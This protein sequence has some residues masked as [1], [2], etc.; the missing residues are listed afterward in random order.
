MEWLRNKVR[1]WLR[2]NSA[3]TFIG[4][5]AHFKGATC[6]VV[7]SKL[8]NGYMKI[9]DLQFGSFKELQHCIEEL[10]Q[11]YKVPN[12]RVVADFPRYEPM[13]RRGMPGWY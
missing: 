4:V 10:Q 8:H 11:R 3:P 5:D 2:I 12:H 13:G 7:A 6:I 9:L 1:K